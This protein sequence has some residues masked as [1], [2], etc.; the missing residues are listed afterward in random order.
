MFIAKHLV[1]TYSFSH[2]KSWTDRSTLN[3][4]IWPQ[5]S[6]GKPH[7]ESEHSGLQKG[8]IHVFVLFLCTVPW[9]VFGLI[10]DCFCSFYDWMFIGSP[11]YCW[12]NSWFEL[13]SI[14]RKGPYKTS[15]WII[16]LLIDIAE[17]SRLV[18]AIIRKSRAIN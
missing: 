18:I 9:I 5:A 8:G 4:D 6:H 17:F 12:S 7:Q 14:C 1:L 3:L 15:F 11:K 16:V 13:K 10:G 2:N